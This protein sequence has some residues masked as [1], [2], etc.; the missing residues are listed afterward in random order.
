[1]GQVQAA[2]RQ[3]VPSGAV[4]KRMGLPGLGEGAGSVL[5]S[6]PVLI[7]LSFGSPGDPKE[8]VLSRGSG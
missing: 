2:L 6:W 4:C 5:L 3:A 7:L 8:V 1:M